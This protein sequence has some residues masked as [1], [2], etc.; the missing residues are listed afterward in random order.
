MI[1]FLN[2]GHE[3][4]DQT[5]LKDILSELVG[6]ETDRHIIVVPGANKSVDE[7]N[8]YISK[9][10]QVLVIITSDEGNLFPTEQLVHPDMKVYVEY[11]QM[12]NHDHVDRFFPIG[13]TPKTRELVKQRGVTAKDDP[14]SWFFA[15]QVN[16]DSRKRL[17][18]K[19]RGLK[20]GKLI[21]SEGFSQGLEYP[22]YVALT[23]R[24][25]VVPC[26]GGPLSPDSFRLYEALEAGAIPIADNPKWWQMMYGKVPFPTVD[27]WDDIEKHINHY[28]DRFDIANQ[29]MAWWMRT[30]RELLY[31]LEDDLQVPKNELTVLVATSPVPSNPK[32]DHIEETINSVRE[33]LPNSEI[34][35]MIDGVRE[36]QKEREVD[37]TEYTRRLLWKANH[38][39]SKVYPLVFETHHHQ[40]NMTREALKYVRTPTILFMEHDVPLC[41]EIPFPQIIEGIKSG[42]ANIVRLHYEAMIH[43]EHQHL[44][45]DTVPQIVKGL[46]MLRT[47]QWSQRPHVASTEFYRH[48]LDTYFPITA[49][50]MIE[51]LI[52]GVL[53]NAW[54]NRGQAGWND[55]KLWI[56]APEGDMKRSLHSD[57]REG[58]SK[59]E[60]KY[61]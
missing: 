39:W 5:L 54:F 2:D 24:A 16:H 12:P 3:F 17:A 14:I 11:P 31:K 57:A 44:M 13:Y 6:R 43:P 25:R 10:P 50:T 19:L 53:E 29:S 60:M 52:Y 51:D 34:I 18:E 55:F 56:Y 21:E 45:L 35:L 8:A 48:I 23:S 4:W 42:Q 38:E 32:T 36:E 41:E 33:R 1:E 40:A 46:P 9:L 59:F 49:N 30:K 58:E 7:V 47:A 26:P 27:N 37:Y 20:G 61:E 28:K 22:E 15:G